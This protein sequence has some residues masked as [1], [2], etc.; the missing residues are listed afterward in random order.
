MHRPVVI[1]GPGDP[2]PLTITVERVVRFEEVDPLGIVWHGRYPGYF[3]D[4]R[5]A[6]GSRHGIGYLDFAGNGVV[7]PIKQLAVEYYKPLRF[8]DRFT[9]EGILHWSDAAKMV[10]EFIIRNG[11]G[12]VA[13]RGHTVQLMIDEHE[14]LLLYPPPFYAEFC[15]RWKEGSL[16]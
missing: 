8:M 5:V 14:N 12:E 13:T 3:E 16:P 10:H 15:R 2:A 11:A 7:T 4:A 1:P 9:I 6:L